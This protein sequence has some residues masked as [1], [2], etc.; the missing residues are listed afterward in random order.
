MNRKFVFYVFGRI[1]QVVAL[2]M[3]LPAVVSA[4]Y[5]ETT[6][7]W[8]FLI[9]AASSAAVGTVIALACRT[10]NRIIYAKEGFA[11]VALAWVG[12]SAVGA[13]PF[14]IS[15]EIPSYVDALFETVSGFTTTGASILRD[16]EAMSR[17]MLFWRSFTHWVGGMGVLV[18]VMAI[19]S[20][21]TDRSI[22]I[23]R[24]E[25]PGPVVGKLVPRA[26]DTAKILYLIYIALTFIEIIMLAVGGMPIF[27]SIVHTFGT[28]GTGGFGIK[29]DSIAGYS[30]YCQNVIATFMII[31][32]INFNLFYLL[33]IRRFRAVTKS[34][35]LWVYLGVI[36]VSVVLVTLNL[37]SVNF[38]VADS[39]RLAYFQVTSIITTSGFST[40]DFNAWPS[41]SK[42][43]LL[44]LM[45]FGGCAGSTAGGIKI[46]RVV[47]LFKQIRREFKRM[48]HPRS[49]T[50]VEFEGK[51][52]DNQTLN[53]VTIYLGIYILSFISIFLFI[54]IEPF[55][56]E[57]NFTA[58]AATFNNVG[59]G[60]GMVGPAGSFADYS[61]FS[62]LVFSFA[63][64]LGR[65]EIFPLLIALSPSTWKRR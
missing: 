55:D 14:V 48:L 41:L 28:A 39:L 11:V 64:L 20:N 30:V 26:K 9:T 52:V 60:F 51:A 58:V 6:S 15:G 31:F 44:L 56:F 40:A 36:A 32:G 33:L 57:T 25:M 43:I 38:N 18:F 37:Y 29:S 21:M 42:A 62:K 45:C 46:S 5:G 23:M 34:T 7:L 35:E 4:I 22:H 16:I 63:M 24:A 1:L 3:L 59:P 2:L 19:V 47:I 17:G 12:M 65:L 49:V 61:W 53:S 27:D 8:A 54:C 10:K 50:S 13:V